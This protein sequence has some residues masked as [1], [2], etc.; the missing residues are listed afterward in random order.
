MKFKP[1]DLMQGY[2][3]EEQAAGPAAIFMVLHKL[4]GDDVDMH[5]CSLSFML[6]RS[7]VHSK[8]SMDMAAAMVD[9]AIKATEKE[10]LLK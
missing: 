10:E 1:A 5:V 9:A 3:P 7:I 6:G 4:Y 2:T 8:I